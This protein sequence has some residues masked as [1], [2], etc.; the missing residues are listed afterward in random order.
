MI[1]IFTIVLVSKPYITT[2]K[3]QQIIE[4]VPFIDD[5]LR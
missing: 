3:G 5:K 4:N 2:P 1:F